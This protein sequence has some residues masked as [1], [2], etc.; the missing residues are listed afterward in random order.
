[1]IPAKQFDTI[2][3]GTKILDKLK[4]KYPEISTIEALVSSY[5]DNMNGDELSQYICELSINLVRINDVAA[6]FISNSNESYTYRKFVQ[7]WEFNAL[8]NKMAVKERE[9]IALD[10]SFEFYKMELLNKYIADVIKAK[11][12]SVNKLISSIQT[13]LR[14]VRAEQANSNTQT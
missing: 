1:M 11:I 8:S 12:D 2:N 3:E 7:L 5:S 13:R 10:N 6:Q 4:I 14:F 9:Q